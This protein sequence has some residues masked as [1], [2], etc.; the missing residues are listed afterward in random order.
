MIIMIPVGYRQF[1]KL[2]FL[3]AYHQVCQTNTTTTATATA[4]AT[5]AAAAA[6]TTTTTT[7]TTITTTTTTTDLKKL[8]TKKREQLSF[9]YYNYWKKA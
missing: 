5:A 6:A 4:T 9:G 2:D 7:T 8:Y 3:L 1:K